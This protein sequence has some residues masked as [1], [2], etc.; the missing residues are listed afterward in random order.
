MQFE[1]KCVC[2]SL[3]ISEIM[4]DIY[5][6]SFDITGKIT[7]FETNNK[8]KVMLNNFHKYD[9]VQMQLRVIKI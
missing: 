8:L 4:T 2:G 5:L 3:K 6:V 9:C 7:S 1:K